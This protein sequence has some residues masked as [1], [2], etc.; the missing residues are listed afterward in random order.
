MT[1]PNWYVVY[2]KA[3]CELKVANFLSKK[4][5]KNYCPLYPVYNQLLD[6][7]KQ[8]LEPLFAS[9]VFVNIPENEMAFILNVPGV[10]NYLYWLDK[11]AIIGEGEIDSLVE[12]LDTYND[13]TLEKHIIPQN[14]THVASKD[15]CTE[16]NIGGSPEL[17]TL[18]LPS[19]GY[20]I[21]ARPIPAL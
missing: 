14:K 4:Q 3:R 16:N 17:I 8:T 9:N 21:I 5:I 6:S 2:T 1:K 19:L 11:P 10:I 7:K 12:L 13:H 18:P 15:S 20:C